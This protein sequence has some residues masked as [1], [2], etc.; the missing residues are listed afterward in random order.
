MNW[1]VGR[2]G[3]RMWPLRG[4]EHHTPHPLADPIVYVVFYLYVAPECIQMWSH[5]RRSSCPKRYVRLQK[6]FGVMC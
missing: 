4:W 3:F 5:P 2:E 6:C 1:C